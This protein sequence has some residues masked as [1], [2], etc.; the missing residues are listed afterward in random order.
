MIL[1]VATIPGVDAAGRPDPSFGLR[2]E[3][4]SDGTVWMQQG[5]KRL[6]IKLDE[7]DGVV[8]DLQ[9]GKKFI[10]IGKGT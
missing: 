4:H 6:R 1:R 10:Q 2:M 5:G 8:K 3:V 7:I 9:A